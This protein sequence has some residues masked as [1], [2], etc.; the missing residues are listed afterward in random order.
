[1]SR[2]RQT[3][4]V[5][6]GV[7]IRTAPLGTTET[8]DGKLNGL[9]VRFNSPTQIGDPEEDGFREEFAPGSFTKT[10]QERDIVLLDNH[11]SAKPIARLSAGTLRVAQSDGLRWDA[12]PADTSYARDAAVNVKAGNYGGC[13]F[14]FRA[15][16][17]DW[18]DDDGNPSDAQRGTHRVVRE[19]ELPEISICTFPAYTDTEVSARDAVS[20]A[21][22]RRAA[23]ASYSDLDTCG[24][25]G[26]TGQY[27]AYCSDC[28]EPMSQPK[29][30]NK[31]CPSCGS[32][33]PAGKR[34][35]HVCT[36]VRG[37]YTAD[38]KKTMLDKGQA[39]A[40]AKGDPSYPIKDEEDLDNAIKAVGRGG[41]DHDAIRKHVMA[42]AKALGL[43]SKIPDTWNADGSLKETNSAASD[44][45]ETRNDGPK[46]GTSTSE[47]DDMGRRLRFLSYVR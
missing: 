12:D 35:N 25:C 32:K 39:M 20:A 11:D 24:E 28:G 43:S 10:I 19:A 22:E 47:L 4:N 31:F 45:T 16:K 18:L 9:A 44:G 6:S 17:E 2:L 29:P 26:S 13:S 34:D 30:S 3:R 15:I 33:V 8:A 21:R 46:P 40:N 1:M 37:K 27:G 14:G 23:K 42:R 36:E 38:E 7:E 41:A 5:A